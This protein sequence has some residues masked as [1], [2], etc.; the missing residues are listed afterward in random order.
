MG[1]DPR[2]QHLLEEILD[3]DRSPEEVCSDCA[4]LL[5]QVRERLN[6]FR[7]VEAQVED[8]FPEKTA[9]SSNDARP[10]GAPPTQLPQIAGYDVQT[11]LGYGGMG[12]VYKALDLRLNRPVAIK[13]LLTGTYASPEER[14]RFFREAEV[15]A[16]LRH[17]NIVQVYDVGNHDGRPY[18]TLEFVEGGTLAQQLGGTPQPVRQAAMLLVTLAKA[19]EVAHQGGIIHRDL[20]PANVLLTADG[21]PKIADFGL[22]RLLEGG[23]ALTLSGA[24]VGTPSYMAPEQ[25]QGKLRSVGPAIDIY[26]LGAILYK[27]LTGRPPFRAETASETEFQVITQEPVPPSRLNARVPRDIETICLKCLEKDPARRYATANELA[28]DLGRFLESKPI[29]SPRGDVR[30]DQS[31]GQAEPGP[32]RL[33]QRPRAD[34]SPCFPGDLLA[35]AESGS[36]RPVADYRECPAHGATQQSGRRSVAGRASK[37]GRT[38]GAISL[39]HRGGRGGIATREQRHGSA[40]SSGSASGASRLGVAPPAQPARQR[41]RGDARGRDGFAV[42]VATANNQPV[43][44]AARH[45]E[46]G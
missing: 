7:V 4:E 28:A 29:R 1:G 38:L 10:L 46:P 35:M 33:A 20:K 22:A 36:T 15:A 11:L 8:L 32:G 26:S 21:T 37:Q 40:G 24:A 16:G 41:T 31:V 13:M 9:T 2:V 39:K 5:P 45:G 27:L 12:V 6:R 14:E 18:F 25:A 23:A 19:V 34:R 42:F 30:P 44:T 43:G 3:S 17:P